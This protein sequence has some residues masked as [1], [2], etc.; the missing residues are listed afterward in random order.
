MAN[1]SFE[2][3]GPI[4]GILGINAA[5]DKVECGSTGCSEGFVKP[6]I[7]E[8]MVSAGCIGSSS[9]SL[10]LDEDNARSPSILFGG[11]DTARFAGPLV[12]L[13]TKSH[14]RSASLLHTKAHEN[15]S[16][17]DRY[18]KQILRLAKMTTRLNG[19]TQQT[20]KTSR[21]RDAAYLDT[22]S[23]GFVLPDDW[24]S[25]IFNDLRQLSAG[26][27]TK[28]PSY[29]RE[30]VIAC[31]DKDAGISLTFTFADQSGNSAE[32]DV[33]LRELVVPLGLLY[34]DTMLALRK[35]G[36]PG[37]N[38]S[39]ICVVDINKS[40]TFR[41]DGLIIL[42][43][44]FFRSAYT[45]NNLDQN[46]ISIAKPAYNSKTERIVPVGKGPVPKLRGTG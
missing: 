39:D 24:V 27:K 40:S 17:P 10:F 45:Y 33:P 30:M 21:S 44:P 12:T 11:V 41:E 7:S 8:A 3:H 29:A 26:G 16:I 25:S 38:A 1:T 42:G 9:Y 35:F 2:P 20:Y 4:T 18:P 37:A 5:V 31:D 43:D 28:T 46:T 34:T 13:H 23:K 19:T 6:T 15:A 14:E 32:V 36:I 22:G